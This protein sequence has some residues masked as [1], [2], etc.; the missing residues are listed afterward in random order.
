MLAGGTGLTPML[1][2]IREIIKNKEDRTKVHLVFANVSE[3]DI[4]LKNELDESV[5]KHPNIKVSYIVTTASSKSWKGFT[6]FV[7]EDVIKKTMPKPSDDHLI[8]V[9]G[10]PGF[11]EH[12]SGNKTKDF[13]QGELT[14]LLKK[15]GYS[16]S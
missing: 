14:G 13:K 6:G 10:P 2:I 9:C 3:E 7:N 5:R 1:Q 15:L 11:M 8:L 16:G 4:L 12:I